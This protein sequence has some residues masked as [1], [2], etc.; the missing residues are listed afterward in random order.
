[1]FVL[2]KVYL[3]TEGPDVFVIDMR[4]EQ[5]KQFTNCAVDTKCLPMV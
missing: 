5:N 3:V 1:M 4:P 2:L